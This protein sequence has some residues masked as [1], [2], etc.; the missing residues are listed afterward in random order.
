MTKVDSF[1]TAIHRPSSLIN[2]AAW[3]GSLVN[4]A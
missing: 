4:K 2:T 3:V 1:P